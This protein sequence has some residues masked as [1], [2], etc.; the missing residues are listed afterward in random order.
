MLAGGQC[1]ACRLQTSDD[2]K[3]DLVFIVIAH[4]ANGY[5][6]AFYITI[7]YDV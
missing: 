4:S 3:I 7:S 6:A 1:S 5:I 2:R